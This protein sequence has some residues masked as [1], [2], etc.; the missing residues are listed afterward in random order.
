MLS[1]DGRLRSEQDSLHDRPGEQEARHTQGD[2]G[3]GHGHVSVRDEY[4]PTQKDNIGDLVLTAFVLIGL[5]VGVS[6]VAGAKIETIAELPGVDDRDVDGRS[7]RPTVERIA[8]GLGLPALYI[9]TFT[10]LA[11][12]RHASFDSG[13]FVDFVAEGGH[14]AATDGGDP[15]NVKSCSPVQAK[16]QRHLALLESASIG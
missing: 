7:H 4:V 14:F 6:I 5:L 3:V 15:T 10:W 1:T 9:F 16:T 13:G 8:K 12:Q 2:G 11:I